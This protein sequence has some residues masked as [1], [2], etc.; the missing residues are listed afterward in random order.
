MS[1]SSN[2]KQTSKVQR[3][4]GGSLLHAVKMAVANN[5]T[6]D[7]AEKL[8][9]DEEDEEVRAFLQYILLLH[10]WGRLQYYT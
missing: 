9:S 6:S 5:T 7:V 3:A 1:T 8:S 4:R 10:I 2:S